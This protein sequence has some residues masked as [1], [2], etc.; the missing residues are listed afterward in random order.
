MMINKALLEFL[1]D[2]CDSAVISHYIS[3]DYWKPSVGSNRAD[4]PVLTLL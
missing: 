1:V 2:C 3:T 4:K